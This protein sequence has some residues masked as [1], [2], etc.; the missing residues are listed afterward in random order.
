MA[1]NDDDLVKPLF[2]PA[3]D[4]LAR[5]RRGDLPTPRGAGGFT[6]CFADGA[7]VKPQ[8]M[9]KLEQAGKIERPQGGSMARP[10]T[11]TEAGKN[12]SKPVDQW[13]TWPVAARHVVPVMGSGMADVV[14][15]KEQAREMAKSWNQCTTPYVARMFE[16]TVKA[17]GVGCTVFVV[18][19][20]RKP[21]GVK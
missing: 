20:R 6:A 9:R 2:L 21:E 8:V 14:K 5:M 4:V 15:A 1:M 10:Y 19:A 7:L 12:A 3:T 17:G 18:V 11:L 16:R 13:R